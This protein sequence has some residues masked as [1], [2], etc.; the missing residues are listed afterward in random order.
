[1]FNN[2]ICGNAMGTYLA[3]IPCDP[4]SKDHYGY[5]RSG[6]GGYRI[7]AK[8]T[9]KTDPAI[10]AAGCPGAEGCGLGGPPSGGVYNYCLAS[11]VTASAIGTDDYIPGGG[12][13]PAPVGGGGTPTPTPYIGY[14]VVCTS[15]GACVWFSNP[16]V[17]GCPVWARW[18]YDCPGFIHSPETPY[19]GA[20]GDSA[21]R[22]TE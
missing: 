21:N 14:H 7:C 12:G 15:G 19:S 22:C 8:L 3:A 13:P 16:V 2:Y 5:F 11:G 20:C 6:G 17:H 18:E 9:D 4:V 10:A 1:D